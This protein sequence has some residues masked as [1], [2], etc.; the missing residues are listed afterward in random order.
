MCRFTVFCED[1]KNLGDSCRSERT[2]WVSCCCNGSSVCLTV[3]KFTD[4]WNLYAVKDFLCHKF[5][6]PVENWL[7]IG[8][9][10]LKMQKIH[11]VNL[12]QQNLL[13]SRE[14]IEQ[15]WICPRC[16]RTR[17][18]Q[19]LWKKYMAAPSTTTFARSVM[20]KIHLSFIAQP[21]NRFTRVESCQPGFQVLSNGHESIQRTRSN[22]FKF[23]WR[24]PLMWLV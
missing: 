6:D 9:L 8:C 22:G 1:L 4:W 15:H 17:S 13:K 10:R 20:M 2:C 3:N 18:I 5:L 12:N 24:H 7:Y 14:I 19:M 11:G 16:N 21:L 23:Q